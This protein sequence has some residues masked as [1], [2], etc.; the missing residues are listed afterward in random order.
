VDLAL[1][2]HPDA[3][4]LAGDVVDRDNRFFE[5]L[6]PFDHGVRKLAEAG[7]DVVA[8]AG[9]HD[10]DVLGR[11]ASQMRDIPLFRVLGLGNGGD[12]WEATT[13]AQGRLQVIGWSFPHETYLRD[14]SDRLADA[15]VS[16]TRS[17]TPIVGLLHGHLGGTFG[18]D[19][20]KHSRH[21]PIKPSNLANPIVTAWLLGHVH[22]PHD[23]AAMPR[24][25]GYL[26]SLAALDPTETGTHGPWWMTIDGKTVT[27]MRHLALAPLHWARVNIDVTGLQTG[28]AVGDAILATV[29][30]SIQQQA[31][32]TGDASAVGVRVAL[33]GRTPLL[34]K[35]LEEFAGNGLPG[36]QMV[37]GRPVFVED[38]T[39][40]LL[41]PDLNLAEIGDDP[42][43]LG[44]LAHMLID[45]ETGT[46][47]GMALLD[48]ALQRS[49][50]AAKPFTNAGGFRPPNLGSVRQ[51]F[52]S[53]GY[54]LFE[55]IQA[56]Q[57]RGA[58]GSKA[59]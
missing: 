37:D 2:D 47:E 51:S 19:D 56:T 48:V 17:D 57:T 44:T 24:P 9:N 39:V 7:M 10:C 13:V 40:D 38:V 15:L 12:C 26:G 46:P 28:D 52:L 4:L 21:A 27:S 49:L 58:P 53:T 43:P 5:A 42:G 55:D 34:A 30:A 25:V 54:R 32:N 33:T 18:P 50:A 14:P 1:R 6:G 29:R 45:V 16:L 59:S 36:Y 3:V 20:G 41:K 11:V 23:L 8:V 22:K 35:L 31:A